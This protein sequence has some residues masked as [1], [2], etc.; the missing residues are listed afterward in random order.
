MFAAHLGRPELTSQEG[1]MMQMFKSVLSVLM[2]LLVLG[3]S[4]KGG[5]NEEGE[6][7]D[8]AA[9]SREGG[10]GAKTGKYG[11]GRGRSGMGGAAGPGSPASQRVIYFE[12]DSD[13]VL[14]EY[15][16][17][18]TGNAEY[19]SSHPEATAVLQGHADERGS[20]EY[21]IALGERRAM[22]VAR[23]MRLQGV[24]DRQL[25]IVSYGEE[26]PATSGHDESTWQRNRRVE[27]TYQGR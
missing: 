7:G 23:S 10:R 24:G 12:Y 2:M 13:D 26:K 3:C 1:M 21:N 25:Q 22:S 14:P 4:S 17:V 18:V 20:S 11:Y 15:Q 19:L 6:G 27:I 9:A 8:E 16:S 5:V